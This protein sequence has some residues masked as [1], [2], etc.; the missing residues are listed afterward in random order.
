MANAWTDAVERED[1]MDDENYHTREVY[2]NFG[3]AVY[4]AQVLEHGVVNLLTL[5]KIFPGFTATREKFESVMEQY[6][7]Q[8][9]GQLARAVT[10][11]VGDDAQLLAD[12][13]RAVEIRNELMHRYWRKKIGLTQTA[14]GRNRIISELRDAIR[15]FVDVDKRLTPVT[16]KY[17]AV[18]GVSMKYIEALTE[19]QRLEAVALDGFLPGEIPDLSVDEHDR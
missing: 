10:P 5:A 13:K 3:L 15:L 14:R 12:L 7:K 4:Y 6:F 8:V 2:A 1:G 17:A 18:R 11:H 9:F 16:L 19:E